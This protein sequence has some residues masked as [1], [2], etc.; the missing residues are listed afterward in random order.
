MSLSNESCLVSSRSLGLSLSGSQLTDLFHYLEFDRR[1]RMSAEG[2]VAALT[3]NPP[4]VAVPHCNTQYPT[5]IYSTPTFSSLPSFFFLL[6]T[7]TSFFSS[8]HLPSFIC[9]FFH[10]VLPFIYPSIYLPSHA[11][12]ILSRPISTRS[13]SRTI[14]FSSL[15]TYRCSL[16]AFTW[17]GVLSK[18]SY[19]IHKSFSRC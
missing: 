3:T 13:T 15:F 12:F 9:T 11:P 16:S 8:L 2:G 18:A 4:C 6:S 17:L 14:S 19:T 5:N 7:S 1:Y 10:H